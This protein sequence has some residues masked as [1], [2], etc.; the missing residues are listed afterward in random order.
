MRRYQSLKDL[1]YST[2]SEALASE[3]LNFDLQAGRL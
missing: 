3:V 1:R 2:F